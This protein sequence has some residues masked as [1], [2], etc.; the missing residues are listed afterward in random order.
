MENQQ[1]L[2]EGM[3]AVP[4]LELSSSAKNYLLQTSKWARFLS[5]LGFI[6]PAL[7]IVVGVSFGSLA[8]Q[9]GDMSLIVGGFTSFI[10]I[11]FIIIGLITLYPAL[12]LFQFSKQARKAADE[13]DSQ[14]LEMCLKRIRS[15]FRFYGI[16]MIIYLAFIAIGILSAI[17]GLGK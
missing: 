3:A 6:F 1:I 15:F 12:R 9:F 4:S 17:F 2:D 11:F 10:G 8:N 14:A 5:I 7:M 16:I 13:E